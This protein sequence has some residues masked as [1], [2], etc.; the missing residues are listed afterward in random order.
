MT[1]ICNTS[2]YCKSLCP[3]ASVKLVNLFE[4]FTSPRFL[5]AAETNHVYVSLLLEIFNNIVQYHTSWTESPDLECQ[6][7][8]DQGYY[9]THIKDKGLHFGDDDQIRVEF[10]IEGDYMDF[11]YSQSHY[12]SRTRHSGSSSGSVVAPVLGWGFW[13]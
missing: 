11:S 4:L 13:I 3:V 7:R 8:R 2:P 10:G 9:D 6:K 12:D 1:I 5:Y